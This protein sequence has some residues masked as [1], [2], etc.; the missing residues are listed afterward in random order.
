MFKRTKRRNSVIQNGKENFDFDATKEWAKYCFV[1]GER[2]KRT[3]WKSLKENERFYRYSDW[4]DSIEVKY[5]VFS[6]ESLIEFSAYLKHK[7]NMTRPQSKFNECYISAA[8]ST[9]MTLLFTELLTMQVSSG[10]IG[11]V[12]ATLLG[13]I[14]MP[15][16]I[17][18]GMVKLLDM[19]FDDSLQECFY[20]DYRKVIDEI[21]EEKKKNTI[22]NRKEDIDSSEKV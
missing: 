9:G 14:I 17:A 21:I 22:G 15:I 18:I 5:S 6:K 12:V 8:I 20:Q 10:S 4:E 1:C 11:Y 13:I 2:L 3:A 19:F 16:A 7:G